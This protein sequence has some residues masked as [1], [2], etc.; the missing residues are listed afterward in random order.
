LIIDRLFESV[1]NKGNV[2]IGLDTDLEYIPQE[3]KNKF[4]YEDQALY[5]FNQQIIDAT[6][7]VSACYKVQIAYYEALGLKGLKVY[8]AQGWHSYCGY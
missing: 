5:R 7:D 3:F 2:C 4:A 8:K 6:F 1:E